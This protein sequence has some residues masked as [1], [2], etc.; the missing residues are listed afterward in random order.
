M[1]TGQWKR[2]GEPG[3]TN[4]AGFTYHCTKKA[5]HILKD[6]EHADTKNVPVIRW[7][8]K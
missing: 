8:D 3:G 2:C 5:G 6:K 7:K 1:T 4:A